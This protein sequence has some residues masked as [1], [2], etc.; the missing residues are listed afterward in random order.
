M[1]AELSGRVE[2]AR[3][4][5]RQ[6]QTRGVER[7]LDEADGAAVERLTRQVLGARVSD[8]QD[9]GLRAP[10]A[11]A[12][13]QVA[14]RRERGIGGQQHVGVARSL[15]RQ[16][17]DLRQAPEC[18]PQLLVEREIAAEQREPDDHAPPPRRSKRSSPPLRFAR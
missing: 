13:H 7:S 1:R 17:R 4:R 6:S 12:P 3:R 2:G 16:Q 18:A 10:G 8:Q 14:R 5:Q 9:A 11:L 15:R